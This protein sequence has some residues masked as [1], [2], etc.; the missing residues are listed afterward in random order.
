MKVNGDT[1]GTDDIDEEGWRKCCNALTVVG[2]MPLKATP[3]HKRAIFLK[4]LQLDNNIAS[5]KG[6]L[7]LKNEKIPIL[8]I[9]RRALIRFAG[10]VT[11]D[12]IEVSP[13][14]VLLTFRT[15]KLSRSYSECMGHLINLPQMNCVA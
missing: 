15:L 3:T 4:L 5:K 10:T 7:P 8:I 14:H 6:N 12:V 11:K 9:L 1:N 13:S 2:R